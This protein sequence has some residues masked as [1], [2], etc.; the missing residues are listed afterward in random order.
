MRSWIVAAS[1]LAAAGCARECATPAPVTVA[2]VRVAAQRDAGGSTPHV[3]ETPAQRDE[4]ATRIDVDDSGEVR[5]AGFPAIAADGSMV[6]SLEERSDGLRGYPNLTLFVF[7]AKAGG[8]P[9][10]ELTIVDVDDSERDDGPEAR[11]RRVQSR[12]GAVRRLLGAKS[13]TALEEGHGNLDVGFREPR[14]TV[15]GAGGRTLFERDYRSWS[16]PSSGQRGTDGYCAHEPYI[17]Q[18]HSDAQRRV[19]LVHVWYHSSAP[20]SC[21]ADEQ[22]ELVV[23]PAR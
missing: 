22:V 14:L 3:D 6:V 23:V 7:D 9:R 15:R 13:W 18:T 1:A 10:E 2:L 11:K 20:D 4:D 5:F 17:G 12:M 19:V 8:P 16:L 21:D